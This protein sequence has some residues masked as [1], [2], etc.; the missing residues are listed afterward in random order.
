MNFSPYQ[1]SRNFEDDTAP[2]NNNT[3]PAAGS[4]K[5]TP[6]LKPGFL[7]SGVPEY[8]EGVAMAPD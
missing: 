6:G 1:T 8:P 4:R 3:R 5:I 7:G 2:L